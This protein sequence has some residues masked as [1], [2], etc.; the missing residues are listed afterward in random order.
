MYFAYKQFLL[1]TIF[2]SL[3]TLNGMTCTFETHKISHVS[4]PTLIPRS[5][6]AGKQDVQWTSINGPVLVLCSS[7]ICGVHTV[8]IHWSQF[9]KD[10]I[11]FISIL[12]NNLFLFLWIFWVFCHSVDIFE[13]SDSGYYMWL[14]IVEV[15]TSSS[16]NF[17]TW[18]FFFLLRCWHKL[19]S[20]HLFNT[21]VK[22]AISCTWQY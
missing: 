1:R 20:A 17:N 22:E 6:T 7:L 12:L 18:I 10:I 5:I 21:I 15:R 11:R 16:G 8:L 19:A 3:A 14:G 2:L 13:Q 4:F 9:E